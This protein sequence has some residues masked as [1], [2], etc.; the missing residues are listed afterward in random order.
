MVETA[1]DYAI[2]VLDAGGRV[3]S[4]NAG[5]ERIKGYKAAEIIDEHFSKFCP[6][7]ELERGKPDMHLGSAARE[8]RCESKGWRVRKDGSRF[9]RTL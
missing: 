5:A 2:F 7:E 8:G 1:E 3:V 9:W 4:W 6:S